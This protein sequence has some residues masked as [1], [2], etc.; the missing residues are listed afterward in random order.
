MSFTL[1]PGCVSCA[2]SANAFA[3]RITSGIGYATTNP[4][5]LHF[6]AAPAAMPERKTVSSAAPKYSETF[7][8]TSVP[9]ACSNFT[10]GYL[11]ATCEV[12]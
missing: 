12:T 6:A 8:E 9:V 7:L 2:P 4:I 11:A 10:C 3:C 1:I 5:V